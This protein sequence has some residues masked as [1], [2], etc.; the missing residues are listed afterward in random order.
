MGNICKGLS[1]A[2]S[3]ELVSDAL[4]RVASPP[5]GGCQV[6]PCGRESTQTLSGKSI[7]VTGPRPLQMSE[8]AQAS[9]GEHTQALLSL[10]D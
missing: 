2:A 10:S 8:C 5:M 7:Q 4:E 9:P 3:G 1:R 6:L